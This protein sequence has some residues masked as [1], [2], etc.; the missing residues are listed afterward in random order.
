MENIVANAAAFRQRRDGVTRA[1][2]RTLEQDD[3]GRNFR[4]NLGRI[5]CGG[6]IASI[7][8]PALRLR[9]LAGGRPGGKQRQVQHDHN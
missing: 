3:P 2:P 1:R 9:I 6:K 4:K 5:V 7:A 8:G